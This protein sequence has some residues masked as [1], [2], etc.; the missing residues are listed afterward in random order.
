MGVRHFS[1]FLRS[2]L[3]DNRQ[4]A[5]PLLMRAAGRIF[6]LEDL[7]RVDLPVR[8]RRESLKKPTLHGEE[9][10]A[11]VPRQGARP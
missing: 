6:Y 7:P 2:G 3:R 1:R 5:T 4:F 10:S 8:L 9:L 11:E